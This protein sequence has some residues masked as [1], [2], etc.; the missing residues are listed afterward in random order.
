MCQGP[1]IDFFDQKQ[2]DSHGRDLAKSWSGVA[3]AHGVLEIR[4]PQNS[5]FRVFSVSKTQSVPPNFGSKKIFFFAKIDFF[6]IFKGHN[7]GYEA[8]FFFEI[9]LVFGTFLGH[10]CQK[11]VKNPGFL[12]KKNFTR[13]RNTWNSNF[14]IF[15]PSETGEISKSCV[16][17][18]GRSSKSVRKHAT[19]GTQNMRLGVRSKTDPLGFSC[20]FLLKERYNK[21]NEKSWR[22]NRNKFRPIPGRAARVVRT[23]FMSWTG[24]LRRLLACFPYV[25]AEP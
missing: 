20:L 19:Y 25:V 13:P 4:R 15:W 7:V 14:V 5:D 18:W 3:V 23:K 9:F 10:E 2:V 11:K 16:K 22:E 21:N 8:I 6:W 17:N 24:F 1:I 12:D